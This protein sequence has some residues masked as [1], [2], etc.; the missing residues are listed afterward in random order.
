MNIS[1]VIPLLNE[2]ESLNELYNWIAK[3]MQSNSFSYEII[4]IDDGS[5]DGSWK[6]IDLL[7]LKDSNVKGIRFLKNFGKSQALHA[8]FKEA[9]GDVVIT[10]D[11]DL[12]DNPEEIPEMYDLIS[13]K[14]YDLISGWKKKRYDSVIA[15]NLPSKVF[16]A[17]AR[18]TSGVKLHDFNCGLK[19][20][21]NIVV[22]NIDVHGEM[23]RYIPVLAKNAGFSKIGEKV[24][25]HQARKYGKTK[26]GMNRFIN[27]F[28]DLVTIWF[29]SRF[30]KR[31][32]HFFGLIGTILF[33]VG[34]FLSLYLGIDKL[35]IETKGRLIAQRPEFYIALTSMI[36]GTQFFLA[37]F[38]GEIILTSK[39]NKERYN[40]SEKIHL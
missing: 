4:F 28:L 1:V 25:L 32:M 27:G 17:A 12:Q 9:Q 5:T 7:S 8:G 38:L 30:G 14:G 29:M 21:K 24:V 26:F 23:H 35:F 33:I 40:I 15:K 37:G 18:R 19:A 39:R 36:L 10:M 2:Q 11:A 13:N 34:F 20:Y 16:N 31:P 6:T 3:V 22:K